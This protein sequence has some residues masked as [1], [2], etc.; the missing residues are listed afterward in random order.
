MTVGYPRLR[1]V[2][3]GGEY[4]GFV[5]A[6]LGVLLQRIVVPDSVVQ[7]AESAICLGQSVVDLSVH[8]SI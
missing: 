2:Q 5:H 7:S 6:D 8:L 4:D 1:A 3:V